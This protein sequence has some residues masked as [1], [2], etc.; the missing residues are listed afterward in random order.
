H[1]VDEEKTV[2]G[3]LG[4]AVPYGDVATAAV[5]YL[6][7]AIALAASTF[8]IPASWFG[9]PVD[10]PSDEFRRMC[11]TAA[12]RILSYVPR[13]KTE[14]AAVPWERVKTYADNGIS[15]DWIV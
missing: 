13:N 4:T 15:E 9:S 7:E 12:A 6:D 2:A 10:I 11:N 8:T 1:V 3:E 5:G 14:L